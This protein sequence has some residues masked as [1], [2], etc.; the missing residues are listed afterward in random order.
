MVAILMIYGKLAAQQRL[1]P[2]AAAALGYIREA[3]ADA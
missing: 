2:C 3:L 1:I